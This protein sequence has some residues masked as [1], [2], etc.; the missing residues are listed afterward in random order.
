MEAPVSHFVDNV[1]SRS[2][3][4]QLGFRGVGI[5]ERHA[6]LDGVWREVV[7]VELSSGSV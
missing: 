4:C 5:Y 2:L 7:I 6:Q 1:A 3:M